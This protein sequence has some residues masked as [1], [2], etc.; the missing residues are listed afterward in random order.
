MILC[1]VLYPLPIGKH[2][3]QIASSL[4]HDET[5]AQRHDTDGLVHGIE[6]R[7]IAIASAWDYIRMLADSY[8]L[9]FVMSTG[10]SPD[11]P[12]AMWAPWPAELNGDASIYVEVQRTVVR[13][14]ST[15]IVTR[16]V[17]NTTYSSTEER[18]A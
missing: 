2:M 17:M 7:E 18:S 16:L 3:Y 15:D 6:S 12:F 13:D 5:L 9:E 4:I 14:D 8:G 1:L 11:R 10:L